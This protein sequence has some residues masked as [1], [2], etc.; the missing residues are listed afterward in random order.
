MLKKQ[1]VKDA[2]WIHEAQDSGQWQ[3]IVN[4]VLNLWFP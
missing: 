2:N 4:T 3:V 1:D